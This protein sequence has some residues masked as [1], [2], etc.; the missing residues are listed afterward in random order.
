MAIPIEEKKAITK[1][2]TVLEIA[3]VMSEGWFGVRDCPLFFIRPF[4]S[5]YTF[6]LLSFLRSL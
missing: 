4:T 3:I 6:F 5:S 2:R 1:R